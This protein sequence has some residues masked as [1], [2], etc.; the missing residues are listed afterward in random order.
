M[1]EQTTGSAPAPLSLP[2]APNLDWLRK[3]VKR[4]LAE[5]RQ[6]SPAAKLAHAQFDLAK[7]YGFS[8]WRVMHGHTDVVRLLLA[9]GADPTI[10]DSEHD[11]DATGWADFF[12]QTDIV[13][14][15]KAHVKKA[16]G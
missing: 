5:L 13:Q 4:R 2:D 3:E 6:S 7:Q 8:S 15:L 10:H 14:I 16:E 11:S 1:S 12:K 9:A